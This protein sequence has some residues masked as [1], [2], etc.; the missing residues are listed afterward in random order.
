MHCAAFLALLAATNRSSAADPVPPCRITVVDAENGWPVPLVE[1]R[2][3]HNVA[4][5]TDNAGVVAFNLP[6]LM[7]RETWLSVSADGY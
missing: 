2:T 3:V 4:F 6:E 1:L 5:V 7:G